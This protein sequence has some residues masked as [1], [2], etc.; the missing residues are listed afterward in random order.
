MGIGSE[1]TLALG[2]CHKTES[3]HAE[4]MSCRFMHISSVPD[5]EWPVSR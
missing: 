2:R 1:R 3:Y 5:R 4:V